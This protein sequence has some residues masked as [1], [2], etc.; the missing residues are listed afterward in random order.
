MAMDLNKN[1]ETFMMQVTTPKIIF[2][3]LTQKA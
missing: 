3:Y 1:A 2:I